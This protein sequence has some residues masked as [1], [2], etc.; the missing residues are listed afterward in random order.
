[1]ICANFASICDLSIAMGFLQ[2][3]KLFVR[4]RILPEPVTKY[5]LVFM[6]VLQMM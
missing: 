4:A 2:V 5:H 6:C 1:M 3:L